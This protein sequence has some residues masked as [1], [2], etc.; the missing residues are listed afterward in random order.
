MNLITSLKFHNI[1]DTDYADAVGRFTTVRFRMMRVIEH[2]SVCPSPVEW[3][4]QIVWVD[5]ADRHILTSHICRFA[6]CL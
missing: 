6:T 5:G 3:V 2:L 1:P 4:L